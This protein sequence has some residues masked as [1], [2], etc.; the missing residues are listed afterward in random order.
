MKIAMEI[1]IN[2]PETERGVLH[3]DIGLSILIFSQ[4]NKNRNDVCWSC[5][6]DA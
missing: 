4:P 2:K 6:K 1:A 5:Q 3:F